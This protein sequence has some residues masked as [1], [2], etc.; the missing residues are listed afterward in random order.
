MEAGLLLLAQCFCSYKC[1]R[2]CT[3]KFAAQKNILL[4]N[5]FSLAASPMGWGLW[6]FQMAGMEAVR[7]HGNTQGH[8]AGSMK[9][10]VPWCWGRALL[11][12]FI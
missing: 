3:C 10:W 2:I 5:V 11:M 9:L 6:V 1:A 4:P 8:V 12:P 7:H